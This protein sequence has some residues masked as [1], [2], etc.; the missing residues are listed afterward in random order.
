MGDSFIIGGSHVCNHRL[1]YSPE[2]CIEIW[3][4]KDSERKLDQKFW[5]Q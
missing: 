5:L 3:I 4:T 1:E 2:T